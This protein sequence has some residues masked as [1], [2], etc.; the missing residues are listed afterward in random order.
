MRVHWGPLPFKGP[1]CLPYL[2]CSQLLLVSRGL[3]CEQ[4]I[5]WVFIMSDVWAMYCRPD[6]KPAEGTMPI[7]PSSITHQVE[8]YR[9]LPRIGQRA[10]DQGSL[11]SSVVGSLG[12]MFHAR[13]IFSC[14]LGSI[15][16]L[17]LLYGLLY[18]TTSANLLQCDNINRVFILQ[19]C[20][21]WGS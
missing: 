12:L 4:L 19:S 13:L 11:H 20:I 18:Y 14:S 10:K 1:S 9:R 3:L 15:F 8:H 16:L 21:L 5:A 7:R 6:I 17:D 2:S